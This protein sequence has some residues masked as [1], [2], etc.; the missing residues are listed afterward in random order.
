MIGF[1]ARDGETNERDSNVRAESACE[2][3][4]VTALTTTTTFDAYL[5][6]EERVVFLRHSR[7]DVD[8]REKF[9]L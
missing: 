7:V 8:N 1:L 6:G 9:L 3:M 5:Y 4:Q 2:H